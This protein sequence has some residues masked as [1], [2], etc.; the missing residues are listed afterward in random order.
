L[1]LGIVG[2]VLA[3]GSCNVVL[4]FIKADKIVLENDE[5][6]LAEMYLEYYGDD[7]GPHL[8]ILVFVS[9]DI[10]WGE[11]SISGDGEFVYLLLASPDR[12]LADGTYEF[13]SSSSPDDFDMGGGLVGV[14][15]DFDS[16]QAPDEFY[17]VVDG[18][19]KVKE[20]FT[21]QVLVEAELELDDL[22]EG[23]SGPDAELYFQGE[24]ADEFDYSDLATSD[25]RPLSN[26]VFPGL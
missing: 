18:T 15:A 4:G 11:T 2:V 5:Y 6:E 21:G 26:R 13:S 8:Y 24:I 3:L 25:I 17:E 7:A 12:D 1:I 19:V 23:G 14:G 9:D 16:D 22:L 10:R 20:L